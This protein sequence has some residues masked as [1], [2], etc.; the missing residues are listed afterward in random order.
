MAE[1]LQCGKL[2]NDTNERETFPTFGSAVSTRIMSFWFLCLIKHPGCFPFSF[3]FFL[4]N[5]GAEVTSWWFS[6]KI[7][8]VSVVYAFPFTDFVKVYY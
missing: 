8:L 5:L 6:L 4:N 2:Q 7:V 3:F 1:D